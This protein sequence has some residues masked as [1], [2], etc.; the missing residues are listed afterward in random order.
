MIDLFRK[1]YSFDEEKT[2]EGFDIV[3]RVGN[4][5]M[6][7]YMLDASVDRRL[8]GE[9]NEL[10]VL[11]NTAGVSSAGMC[12]R[13]FSGNVYPQ[14]RV[15]GGY[16]DKFMN[17]LRYPNESKCRE[18]A[19][20]SLQEFADIIAGMERI[21]SY[22][23]PNWSDAQKA[24]YLFGV[25]KDAFPYDKRGEK[26]VS[27]RDA[28]YNNLQ[29]LSLDENCGAVCLGYS[30][31]YKELCDRQGIDCE[32]VS[33]VLK[34]KCGSVGHCWNIV[35]FDNKRYLVDIQ[36][37]NSGISF[38]DR[39]GNYINNGYTSYDYFAYTGDRSKAYKPAG[40]PENYE[41]L[42]CVPGMIKHLLVNSVR[43]KVDSV[44]AE[45]S[46]KWLESTAEVAEKEN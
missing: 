26:P 25:L 44:V 38:I 22:I 7:G 6:F 23:D 19:T 33:G 41:E 39:G 11:E 18:S 20:Y 29:A 16:T 28:S 21:E 3:T 9:A 12:K 2:Y 43:A 13:L 37:A 24:T 34:T 10:L 42:G 4:N 30:L 15:I 14:I 46:D 27:L 31:M 40:E 1:K 36:Q 5:D 35:S 8:N 32:M 45:I 17:G